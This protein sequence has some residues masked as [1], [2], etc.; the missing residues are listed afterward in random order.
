MNTL[1]S[2]QTGTNEQPPT[3][4]GSTSATGNTSVTLPNSTMAAQS[5]ANKNL[6]I[7]EVFPIYGTIH[8]CS[9]Y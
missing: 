3:T 9:G 7:H 4:E 1:G 8:H 2:G 5:F 6:Y